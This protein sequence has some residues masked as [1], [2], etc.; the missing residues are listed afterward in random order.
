MFEYK[1][2]FS[3]LGL[4]RELDVHQND[5][6]IE[7]EDE[8]HGTYYNVMSEKVFEKSGKKYLRIQ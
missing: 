4:Q 5:V 1:I 7:F 3:Y 6:I 8:K 2:Q